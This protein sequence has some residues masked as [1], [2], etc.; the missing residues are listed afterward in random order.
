MKNENNLR[1][2]IYEKEEC[3]INFTKNGN[4]DYKA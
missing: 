3:H 1:G 2:N 4:I